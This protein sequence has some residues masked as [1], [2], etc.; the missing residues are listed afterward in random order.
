M[1]VD[2]QFNRPNHIRPRDQD[3]QENT[4]AT[5]PTIYDKEVIKS[6]PRQY[7]ITQLKRNGFAELAEALPGAVNSEDPIHAAFREIADT[8]NEEREEQ[9]KDMLK[10][11][12]LDETNLKATYD[13]I[14]VEMFRDRIHWGKIVTF[15]VFSAHY[16]LC[17]AQREDLRPKI[18]DLMELIDSHVEERLHHWIE[19]QG[20]WQAFVEHY[21]TENWR[22]SVSTAV[23]GLGLGLTVVAGGLMALKNML[24]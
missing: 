20:G 21:E 19:V 16:V 18:A 1:S 13:T 10:T 14:I 24:F 4:L 23:L 11:L 9:M 22:I 6:F 12:K 17:C 7:I 8:L 3:R 2:T 15:V 5:Q